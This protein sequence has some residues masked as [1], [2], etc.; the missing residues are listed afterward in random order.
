MKKALAF[1]GKKHDEGDVRLKACQLTIL[2]HRMGIREMAPRCRQDVS[3]GEDP[4]FSD[5]DEECC[6]WCSG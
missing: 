6:I 2:V 5:D 1:L 3:R 4:A